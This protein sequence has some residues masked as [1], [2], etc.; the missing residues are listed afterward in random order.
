VRVGLAIGAVCLAACGCLGD[1]AEDAPSPDGVIPGR[2]TT[3]QVRVQAAHNDDTLFLRVRF[4]APDVASRHET[5]RR[6]AG[7]WRRE[8]GGFRDLQAAAEGD[9]DRGDVTR[10]SAASETAL[11]VLLDDPS[12]AGRLLSFRETG[13]FG[14]CHERQRQMPNW[15][16]SDGAA[17]MTVWTGFG[18][19]DLWIWRGQRSALGGFADDL[20][21]TPAGYVP[22]AGTAPFTPVTLTTEGLPS[23]VYDPAGGGA[24][25]Q[26][27]SG[28]PAPLSFDDG[29]LD[30]LP[31]ALAIGSAL[32]L[33]YSPADD[34]TVP[35]QRLSLPGGSRA[36]VATA[37]A[38]AG[39]EW[40][41]VFTRRL[42]TGDPAGDLA[43]TSGKP[44]GI[45]F[46]LH[47]DD[48][49]GRDHYVSL[50]VTLLLGTAGEGVTSVA[51]AGTGAAA[52]AFS[53]ETAFPVTELSMFLPGVTSF[54]WLVGAPTTR[55]GEART[56][57]V[58]HGGALE[59]A[60][61]ERR[62]ADC[63]TVRS[64]DP[65]PP[66]ADAGPLERLVLRRGGVYGPTP[67]FEESGE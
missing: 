29:T 60:T 40:D 58:V 44:Y 20:S 17:P 9:V 13:C 5:W 43:L 48:A 38:V 46:A 66:V 18:K 10:T 2:P 53:D 62:C 30:G 6:V 65:A 42:S 34:D 55:D 1:R 4:P 14:Q 52:P 19:G 21:F 16:A 22:D 63:H 23:F 33:G 54:D 26:A 11:S 56:V 37:S 7:E 50:P 67:F 64:T 15:R 41:V 31:D 27:W 47:R 39:G 8:G 57:D 36:D 25:A 24:F 32:L 61:A 45:A 35:A 51:V 12:S 3:L 28:Q 49:D 59:V